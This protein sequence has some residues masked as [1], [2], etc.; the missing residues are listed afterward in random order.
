MPARAA[1]LVVLWAGARAGDSTHPSRRMDGG[2]DA[3]NTLRQSSQR[4]RARLHRVVSSPADRVACRASIASELKGAM[5]HELRSAATT[6]EMVTLMT[7]EIV[8]G[9][10]SFFVEFATVTLPNMFMRCYC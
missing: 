5:R 6:T 10:V 8:G 4:Q 1:L 7:Q 2:E 3:A 9:V